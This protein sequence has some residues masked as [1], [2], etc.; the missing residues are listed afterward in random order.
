MK[1]DRTNTAM[2]WALPIWSAQRWLHWLRYRIGHHL[3]APSGA[4]GQ[5]PSVAVNAKMSTSDEPALVAAWTALLEAMQAQGAHADKEAASTTPEQTAADIEEALRLSL[6]V[7]GARRTVA[8]MMRRG[9][10]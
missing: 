7:A 9:Q 1:S 2:P 6:A 8:S 4:H 5:V 10:R 3:K